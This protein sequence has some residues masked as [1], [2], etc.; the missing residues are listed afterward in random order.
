MIKKIATYRFILL[1]SLL[2]VLIMGFIFS[3]SLQDSASSN[4]VSDSVASGV[5]PLVDPSEKIDL[6]Q[7]QII[8]RKLA[9]AIEFCA[10]GASLGG[11]MYSIHRA[12]KQRCRVF[13]ILFW[14]LGTATADEYIQSFT[15]RTSSV[16][17][18]LIDF[19]GAVV[20]IILASLAVIVTNKI[21]RNTARKRG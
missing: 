17:D 11:L 2:S 9:H 16:E 10:L 1:F 5:K 7:F 8:I 4:S 12:E 21:R 14:A 6:P 19:S 13:M 15:G 20:G 18:I 3:N